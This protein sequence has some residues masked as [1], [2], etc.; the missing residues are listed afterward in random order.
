MSTSSPRRAAASNSSIR[1]S[2]CQRRAEGCLATILW[3]G[4]MTFLIL[5]VCK[6]TTG[7]RVSDDAELEGL[8]MA[9]HGKA[10]G[11]TRTSTRRRTVADPGTPRGSRD[12]YRSTPDSAWRRAYQASPMPS[13]MMNT[14]MTFMPGVFAVPAGAASPC[15]PKLSAMPT[16][17]AM[18]AHKA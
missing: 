15:Q 7:L 8:D 3:S 11:T 12:C 1:T 13:R 2:S 17:E 6:F 16:S 18:N 9:L 10:A 14:I 5:M 4:V